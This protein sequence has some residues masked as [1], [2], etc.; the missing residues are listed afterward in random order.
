VADARPPF[1]VRYR[2]DRCRR[3]LVMD[4]ATRK[5]VQPADEAI[6]DLSMLR[7]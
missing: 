5:L 4:F 2:C 3:V 1:G 6:R 7:R